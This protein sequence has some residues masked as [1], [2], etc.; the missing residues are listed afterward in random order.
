[1]PEY[2]WE[3]SYIKC[4]QIA[5]VTQQAH[6]VDMCVQQVSM[7]QNECRFVHGATLQHVQN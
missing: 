3:Q 1:M 6:P 4:I 2:L 5:L 7:Q